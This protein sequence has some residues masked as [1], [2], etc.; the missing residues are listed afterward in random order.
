MD[1]GLGIKLGAPMASPACSLSLISCLRDEDTA[2][3]EKWHGPHGS[4]NAGSVQPADLQ[5]REDLQLFQNRQGWVVNAKPPARQLPE[6]S[7]KVI[8]LPATLVKIG[9]GT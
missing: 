2:A 1:R 4:L 9:G 5:L 8:P 3:R 6:P 7:R